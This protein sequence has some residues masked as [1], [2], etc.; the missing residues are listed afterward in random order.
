MLSTIGNVLG[1]YSTAAASSQLPGAPPPS[2]S[3]Q[4]VAS[5]L[6]H[7]IDTLFQA[8]LR[9][10]VC[11]EQPVQSESGPISMVAQ[12]QEAAAVAA[13]TYGVGNVSVVLGSDF[14]S[15]GNP[16]LCLSTQ[17]VAITGDLGVPGDVTQGLGS[18]ATPV[19]TVK[20]FGSD[21][22]Q[23]L[24]N[25]VVLHFPLPPADT[26][27]RFSTLGYTCRFRSAV[28][29]SWHADT[30]CTL[31]YINATNMGCRCHH[32]T[33]FSIAPVKK[34]NQPP[35]S[36][37]A[38]EDQPEDKTKQLIIYIVSPVGGVA[39]VL[40]AA[41]VIVHQ[42]RKR[43]QIAGGSRVADASLSAIELRNKSFMDVEEDQVILKADKKFLMAAFSKANAEAGGE[44]DR[45]AT[46]IQRAYRA[47][48]VRKK[49]A[50]KP[51]PS[52]LKQQHSESTG[53]SKRVSFAAAHAP[54]PL[55]PVPTRLPP[56]AAP[57]S[58]PPPPPPADETTV[59]I[60]EDTVNRPSDPAPR[61]RAKYQLPPLRPSSP[62][63]ALLPAIAAS[64]SA[65]SNE[66]DKNDLDNM[67]N[68]VSGT[69]KR[70]ASGQGEYVTYHTD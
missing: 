53:L 26:D 14:S 2:D 6:T 28:N 42:A 37:A 4:Q 24:T 56:I 68:L 55:L 23:N 41:F 63:A 35:V 38:E 48:V 58:L 54:E 64:A 27:P 25:G 7:N 33:D 59:S 66:P 44:R 20:V 8:Q 22:N 17:M 50:K 60:M 49:F 12:Q 52:A 16:E 69:V 1:S 70:E 19:I 67:D 13:A 5:A 29:D 15:D 39:V 43:R 40:V 36:H 34:Q 61:M 9:N 32:L 31:A 45:A 21:D 62:A 11:G 18:A 57:A 3:L 46:K 51:L 65:A 10:R 47:Y 30:S